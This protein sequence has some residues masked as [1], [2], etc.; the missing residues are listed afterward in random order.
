MY[1]RALRGCEAGEVRVAV[2][3]ARLLDD[4]R[5]GPSRQLAAAVRGAVVDDQHLARDAVIVQHVWCKPD[6]LLD[7]L[8][9]VET[10]NDHGDAHGTVARR[11]RYRVVMQGGDAASS[12]PVAFAVVS[13]VPS[14]TLGSISYTRGA[15]WLKAVGTW[16][17]NYV[18][19]RYS[20]FGQTRGSPGES[21]PRRRGR[22]KRSLRWA[23]RSELDPALPG[24]LRGRDPASSPT[25]PGVACRMTAWTTR[26]TLRSFT[27]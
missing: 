20:G 18:V 25:S 23:T 16:H 21:N 19:T 3:A 22:A 14:S 5:S 6:A 15:R 11:D 17:R 13:E 24:P 12:H 7:V 26:D 4:S 1:A 27:E 9:L 8:R 2:T 10:R